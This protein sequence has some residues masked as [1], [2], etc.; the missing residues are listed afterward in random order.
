[1]IINKKYYDFIF[2]PF[3]NTKILLCL[4]FGNVGDQLIWESCYQLLKYNNINYSQLSLVHINNDLVNQIN[5]LDISMYDAVFWVGGGNMGKLYKSNYNF[6]KIISNKCITN[7]KKFIILPQSWT[8]TDDAEADTYY[9]REFYSIREYESRAI[10]A[11]DLALSYEIDSSI[12]SLLYSEKDKK[13]IGYF[14]RIDVERTDNSNNIDPAKICKTY[15]D[16]LILASKYKEIHTN[17][18]H[19]AICGLI[20]GNSVKFYRNS[21]FKNRAIYESSLYSLPNIEWIEK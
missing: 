8:S 12:V 7:N 6:R 16:Y 15:K 1:M 9:A 10:F 5:N 21:Y 19:F 4:P 11:H 2:K 13:E 3:F 18:L 14:F 17:R 20:V